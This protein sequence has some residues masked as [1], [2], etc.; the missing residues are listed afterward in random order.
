MK[1]LGILF[2]YNGVIV[3]DENLQ[4]AAMEQTLAP[5]NISLTEELYE[6]YCWG[7]SDEAG[8]ENLSKTFPQ[9]GA[10]AIHEL[11]ER[12]LK[13]YQQLSRSVSPLH[14]GVADLLQNLSS[15]FR[16]GLV[17]GSQRSEMEPILTKGG[18]KEIKDA[19][20]YASYA[21]R[22]RFK[23]ENIRDHIDYSQA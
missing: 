2:D 21:K 5:W 13:A 6:Q 7:R 8:F 1:T 3:D 16:L 14:P 15:F 18:I 23:L 20:K 19:G 9:L 22:K 11:V 17:T 10:I 4:R 12:K